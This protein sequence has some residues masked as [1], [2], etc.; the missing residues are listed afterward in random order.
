MAKGVRVARKRA[1]AEGVQLRTSPTRP[2][3]SSSGP[4]PSRWAT[5]SRR[6]G[7]W[8]RAGRAGF[9]YP[10]PS[11]RPSVPQSPTAMS[12]ARTQPPGPASRYQPSPGASRLPG[13]MRRNSCA[14]T[15]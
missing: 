3:L 8:L 4:G 14:S 1:I 11:P 6:S 5:A 7:F 12:S 10:T 2:G 15:V 9:G 13:S